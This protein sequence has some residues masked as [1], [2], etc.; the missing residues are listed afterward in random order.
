MA[1][2]REGRGI[3]SIDPAVFR[4]TMTGSCG[5]PA[6]AAAVSLTVT[7]T[8]ST[9]PGFV[10]VW[11]AGTPRPTV[12]NV[13]H[14]T[15][16]DRANGAIVALGVEGAVDVYGSVPTD[17]VLDVTG[18][19]IPTSEPATAGRMVPLTP[20]RIYDSRSAAGPLPRGGSITLP[21]PAGVPADA[22]ALAL[23]LTTTAPNQPGFFTVHPAGTPR[24]L[25]S[26]L[27]TDRPGQ[28]R[29]AGSIVPVSPAG[30][31]IYA[32][33]GGH[34][35]V[36]VTGYVTGSSAPSSVDGLFVPVDPFRL[37][38]TRGGDPV[39][40]AGTIEAALPVTG[41]A[42]VA[43]NVTMV[44]AGAWGFVTAYPARTGLPVTSSV[45]VSAA[46][47]TTANLAV[48]PVSTDGIALTSHA[49]TDALVDVAGWFTG[50][51]AA[52]TLPP[53]ANLRPPVCASGIGAAA[54]T[55]FFDR[56]DP[57]TGVD[58]QRS[59]YLPDGRV[60]WVFQDVFIR[61]RGR[62]V[63]VHNAGLLQTGACFQPLHGGTYANPTDWILPE[64][65]TRERRW[66]W[67]LGGEVGTDGQVN[68]VVAEMREN[69]TRYLDR[70]EPLGTWL[71]TIR[72]SDLAV[73]G[74]A[75]WAAPGP[76]LTGWSITSDATWTYLYGQCHRQ[77][78]WTMFAFPGPPVYAH[79]L[80]CSATVTV[81]R[82]PRG[83]LTATPEYWDGARWTTDRTRAVGVMPTLGRLINP[84][85]VVFDGSRFVAVTKEGDWWGT[86]VL[87]DVA[88]AA[89]GPWRTVAEYT[90]IP[91]CAD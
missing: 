77:F 51:A 16:E 44:E 68:L 24:P 4:V 85:Q 63:F 49:T 60:L 46:G 31:T 3:R 48:I 33:G 87:V 47:E 11:P 62:E 90:S 53:G 27:N 5:V 75:P 10:T 50:P 36:D 12:S 86:K 32:D 70:T 59:I 42:A 72:T 17:V 58:Y 73:T 37:V 30:V 7:T 89:Q 8:R 23:N 88:P 1:D 57:Y 74:A 41:V 15:R 79:D 39:W 81:A 80:G 82:V 38:D 45:N 21:L 19:F 78:G 29:A 55:E 76:D 54:L 13:N 91:L 35:I 65:T 61:S 28:T 34:V 52:S 84:S 9:A 40:P 56:G 71:A 67:P 6:D 66:F 43:A 83:Q 69:G 2:T 25:A 64:L 22:T 20:T 18:W 14:G 26:T